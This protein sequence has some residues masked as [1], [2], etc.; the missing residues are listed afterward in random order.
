[1]MNNELRPYEAYKPTN[2]PW[3]DEIPV[4]W[5]L[6]RNKNVMIQNKAL[7][8]LNHAQYKLLSLTL[9]GV[10]ARDMV[11]PKGKFPKEFD[12]YQV[13]SEKNL[14]FCLFDIDETPRTVGISPMDGMITGAYTVFKVANAN[15]R[16]L[17]YYYLSIDNNKMLKPLYT[18]LRKVISGDTFLR[19]KLPIPPRPEQDQIVK[20]L[21]HQ[22]FKINKFIMAKKKLIAVLKEQKQAV[23]N[24]AVTKGLNSNVKMKPSGIDG[25]G[26]V[27]DHWA[28]LMNRRIFKENCR[29]FSNTEEIVLSL[30]QKDGIIPYAKMKERSLHT[31]TYENW[32][33]VYLNDLVLNRFKAHLGVFF[34]SEYRG[35][36]TFHYGVYEPKVKLI[37]K[38]YEH[39][40]HT[41]SFKSIYAG[42]SN[43]MTIGL[44]NLSNQ[45]FYNV[46][47]LMPQIEEQVE[48]VEYIEREVKKVDL[49]IGRIESE[50]QLISEYKNSLILDIVTGKID[51]RHIMIDE[52]EEIVPLDLEVDEDSL[53]SEEILE[54]EEGDE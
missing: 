40:Y 39:L 25:V 46:Y 10:I 44:Q 37:S 27:P 43:G 4:H 30:S 29:S 36:V 5:S 32:K 49:V 45:N 38:Y 13:V 19:T 54:D 26:N 53:D 35:I 7:V 20:Y 42:R 16:F 50:I 21:D 47:T 18:G 52:T 12:T 41:N 51:V 31:S 33:L 28:I 34:S 11:N 9:N 23:I 48:I 14:V 15:E 8:G 1:M 2:L 24:E 17:Y 6:S 3:L 22:L